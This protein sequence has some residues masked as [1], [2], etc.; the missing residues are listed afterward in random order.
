MR[1]RP[2]R[3]DKGSNAGYNDDG[4]MVPSKPAKVLIV[5]DELSITNFIAD[6]V[7]LL[8]CETRVLTSGSK[9]LAMA[10]EWKPDLITLDVM[11]PAPGGVEVLNELKSDPET[12]S[13]PVFIVS[14]VANQLAGKLHQ[15]QAIFPKP[16]D[17][18]EFIEQVRKTCRP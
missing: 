15:A 3:L 4:K 9:V 14:V 12:A 7:R 13:I 10:K 6:I 1:T 11:M 18:K 17:T 16:I 5:D 8:G 2:Q